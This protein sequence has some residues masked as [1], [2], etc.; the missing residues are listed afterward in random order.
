MSAI[1]T[2]SKPRATNILVPVSDRSLRVSRFLRSRSPSPGTSRSGP[3]ARPRPTRRTAQSSAGLGVRSVVS[4]SVVPSR[5]SQ[6]YLDCDG[7]HKITLD[8]KLRPTYLWVKQREDAM[9]SL[10]REAA[11]DLDP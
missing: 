9:T 10:H 1:V 3:A 11:V 6:S 7:R 8:I 2:S 4:F 5:M